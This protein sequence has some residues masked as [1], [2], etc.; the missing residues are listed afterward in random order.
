M[1]PE[2]RKERFV[3]TFANFFFLK[4]LPRGPI[5]TELTPQISSPRGTLQ[6]RN[7]AK[8]LPALDYLLFVRS[9]PPLPPGFHRSV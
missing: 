9:S 7:S 8:E 5:E 1:L 3:E 4:H 6:E 2:G